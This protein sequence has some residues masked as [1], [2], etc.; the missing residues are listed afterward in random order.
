MGAA[1]PRAAV[2]R[3]AHTVLRDRRRGGRTHSPSGSQERFAGS[4][5][6]TRLSSASGIS[7]ASW[8]RTTGIVLLDAPVWCG[9]VFGGVLNEYLRAA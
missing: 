8:P 5:W 1:N 9:K 4:T 3:R 6:I 2:S 7:A